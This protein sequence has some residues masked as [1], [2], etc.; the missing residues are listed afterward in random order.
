MHN[1]TLFA[2]MVERPNVG[3]FGLE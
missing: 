2:A 1:I 3:I